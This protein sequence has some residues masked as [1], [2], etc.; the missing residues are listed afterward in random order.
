MRKTCK[1]NEINVNLWDWKCAQQFSLSLQ[2][3]NNL[4]Q[5]ENNNQRQKAYAKTSVLQEIVSAITSSVS[6]NMSS[7]FHERL[8]IS[9]SV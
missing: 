3:W 8:N 5:N 6:S 4:K 9:V 1:K 2:I 7:L